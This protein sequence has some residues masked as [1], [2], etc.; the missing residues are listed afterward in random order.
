MIRIHGIS[1]LY[2]SIAVAI[3]T[4]EICRDHGHVTLKSQSGYLSTLMTEETGYGLDGCPWRIKA[5][6][7]QNVELSVMDFNLLAHFQTK[8]DPYVEDYPGWCPVSIVI[9]EE[10]VTMKDI[11]LCNGGQRHKHLYLSTTNQ[12]SVHFVSDQPQKPHYYY[13]VHYKGRVQFF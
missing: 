10:G 13:L 12:V 8:D 9:K 5:H 1:L 2:F 4:P 6:P 7:G 11:T 3:G